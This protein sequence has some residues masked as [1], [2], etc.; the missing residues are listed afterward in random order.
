MQAITSTGG[1]TSAGV[2]T[3]PGSPEEVVMESPKDTT[4]DEQSIDMDEGGEDGGDENEDDDEEDRLR[5][6]QLNLDK[7]DEEGDAVIVE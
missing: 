4:M 6:M 3:T 7:E 1:S 2:N 5:E